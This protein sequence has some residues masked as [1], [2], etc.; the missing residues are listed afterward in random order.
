MTFK[1][2]PFLKQQITLKNIDSNWNLRMRRPSNKTR[3]SLH[4]S[5]QQL[6]RFTGKRCTG[7]IDLKVYWCS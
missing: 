1:I 3:G 6:K 7:A 4:P 5:S 2:I